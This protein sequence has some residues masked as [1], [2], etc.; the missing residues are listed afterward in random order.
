MRLIRLF[1]AAICSA[2]LFVAAHAAPADPGVSR[3]L[4]IA[5]AARLSTLHYALDFELTPHSPTIAGHETLTF[6]D[7][8]SGDLA[9]DYRDGTVSAASL[10]GK[11]IPTALEN[12]HLNLP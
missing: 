10:N 1:V 6:A 12:G 11:E 8:G 3:A 7:S 9:L 4:A 5:R 2:L